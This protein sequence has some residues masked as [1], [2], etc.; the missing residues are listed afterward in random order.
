M[1]ILFHDIETL[2]EC[3][4][5]G[6]FVPEKNKKYEF[7]VNRWENSIDGFIKF[8]EEHREFY[9]VSYNGLRFDSQVIEW[10]IRNYENWHNL[11]G[12]EICSKI[13][14]K[15][16]DTI[17]DS[18]YEVFPEYSEYALS[19]KQIDLMKVSHFDNKN[20]MVSLKRLEFEMDMENVEEMPVPHNKKGLSWPDILTIK[21]YCSNKDVPATAMFWNYM[22]G[23][24]THPLYKQNNQIQ[25]RQDIEAEFKIPCMN[26]SNAKI[27]DEIIKK[28][29]CEEKG[30][31]YKQL[32]KKGFFRKQIELKYCIPKHISFKTKQLQ[33][34]LKETRAKILQRD[35]DFIHSIK[36]YGQEYTFAKGG[37]HNV[38]NG[39]IYESDDENDL[40][41]IDVSGFYPAIIINNS[42][43]PF[44]LGREFLVGY[45][46][47]YFKRIELKPLAKKDK[48]IKGIVG[49]LKEAGNCPYGK[50]SDMQSWL[51]DKQMTLATCLTGEFSLLMLIEECELNGIKCI[52]ANTDGA[53]F[54]VPKT[55]YEEFSRIKQEWREKTT[56]KLTYE[57]EE[58]KYQK[59]VFS[60][61]NDYI[62]IKQD[63]NDPDR[64]KLKGDFMK[65]FE[66]HKNHSARICP[67]ALE[68]YYVDNM[69][70]E[71]T[72]KECTNIYDFAIRQ[73]A[74][75]DFHYEGVKNLKAI[76]VPPGT[77]ES[78]GWFEG[79]DGKWVHPTDKRPL[80][81]VIGEIKR[82][83]L[84]EE[85][86][87][88]YNKLIRYYVSNTGEKLLKVKNPWCKTNAADISQV[89]AGEWVAHVCNY[90]P[91]DH[92]LDN[93]NRS[94]YIEKCQG[95]I[96]KIKLEGKKAVKKQPLNQLGLNF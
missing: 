25:L 48:R 82:D 19:L 55:K 73:K 52:M 51:Y 89:E 26:F 70:I 40:V 63:K 14:Q 34:F 56:V 86:R 65:D 49:G 84:E 27:G 3:F 76:N 28:Y 71:K 8:I 57:L 50:S 31:T 2:L 79:E 72:I 90:L 87:T 62:A 30:I 29:Y 24:V 75:R 66:L 83:L 10:V 96:D 33:D 4:Y 95:I 16:Q 81:D 9:W 35:E 1:K 22:V 59:M 68:K 17:H 13:Y 78:L 92:P 80:I 37:L 32:P 12:L 6:I 69:P 93:V 38:I 94:Y 7:G 15:A 39:R 54:I 21:D 74:S 36:F 42:Y 85:P 18:N 61:V 47:V 46:K 88:I 64:V 45:S 11:S 44:H 41:D 58:V 91:K 77:L 23:D 53:T 5:V 43:Y 67:I 20:R 60:T